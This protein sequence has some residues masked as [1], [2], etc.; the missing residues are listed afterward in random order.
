MKKHTPEKATTLR[1]TRTKNNAYQD[2]RRT[3]KKRKNEMKTTK[4]K[5]GDVI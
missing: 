5:P 4:G 2:A 1:P 3:R